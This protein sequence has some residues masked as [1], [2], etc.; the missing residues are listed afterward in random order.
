M[1]GKLSR[2]ITKK[3]SGRIFKIF[4][5]TPYINTP[6]SHKKNRY[7]RGGVSLRFRSWNIFYVEV[8]PTQN[9]SRREKRLDAIEELKPSDGDSMALVRVVLEGLSSHNKNQQNRLSEGLR[10]LWLSTG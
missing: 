6:T 3:L 8:N 4:F 2:T 10:F 9:R 1:Q 7:P 5:L